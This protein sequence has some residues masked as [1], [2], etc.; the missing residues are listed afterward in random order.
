MGL[1]ALVLF[2]V[3]M[4]D[5]TAQPIVDFNARF[6]KPRIERYKVSDRVR[7]SVEYR[8]DG[9][10]SAIEIAPAE[11]RGYNPTQ[12]LEM[13]SQA[14]DRILENLSNGLESETVIRTTYPG[15]SQ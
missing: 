7:L 10:V 14:V 9:K 15:F 1:L 8:I 5:A 2:A 12:P 13:S 11:Y 3:C 6:G 4:S